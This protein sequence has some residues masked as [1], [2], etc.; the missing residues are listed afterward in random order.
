MSRC[1]QHLQALGLSLP[2]MHVP[3]GNFLSFTTSGNRLYLS[4]K[5]A[6]LRAPLEGPVPKVG[7]EISAEEASR[8][9]RDAGLSLIAVMKDALG[10]LDRVRRV[11]KVLGMVNAVPDF[12]SHTEVID[13]CSN[14]LVEVF[15]D[16]GRHARSAIGVGSLP[17][18]FAVEIEAIVEFD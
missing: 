11:I 14:L 5:G 10:D 4:G 12:T 8:H 7:R 9:A 15:G 6:P 17:K 3:R 16:R 1:E 2:A 13:G 18:G